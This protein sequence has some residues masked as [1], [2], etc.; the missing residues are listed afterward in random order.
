MEVYFWTDG[1]LVFTFILEGFSRKNLCVLIYNIYLF[2]IAYLNYTKR[3]KN[4]L[5]HYSTFFQQWYQS[6]VEQPY[7][8]VIKMEGVVNYDGDMIKLTAD[9]YSYWKAMMKDHLICKD[10]VE[11]ILNKNM[12]KGKNEN[13]KR[14]WNCKEVVIIR[15]YIDKRLFEHVSNFDNA[16]ELWTKL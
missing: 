8:C 16:Y 14:L 1:P 4:L 10:L 9:N 13:E 7:S 12:P 15:K 11:P 6:H 2:F 3:E 5:L